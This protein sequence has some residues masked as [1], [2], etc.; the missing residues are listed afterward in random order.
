MGNRTFKTSLFT[1]S[2]FTTQKN[3]RNNQDSFY[4]EEVGGM[5]IIRPGK[6]ICFK[7]LSAKIISYD[8]SPCKKSKIDENKESYNNKGISDLSS[9]NIFQEKTYNSSNQDFPVQQKALDNDDLDE[10]LS[11]QINEYSFFSCENEKSSVQNST[12]ISMINHSGDRFKSFLE[13]DE[14]LN[15]LNY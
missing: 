15:F 8:L 14:T 9:V 3:D 12:E 1:R 5:E 10:D 6:K 7:N 4:V 13:D 2:Q 11:T